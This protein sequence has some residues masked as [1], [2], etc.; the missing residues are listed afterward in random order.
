MYLCLLAFQTVHRHK[1]ESAPPWDTRSPLHATALSL[2][3]SRA[4]KRA[5]MKHTLSNPSN[6]AF[7]PKPKTV[8]IHYTALYRDTKLLT[9]NQII[10]LKSLGFDCRIYN[11][12]NM[13]V[14]VKTAWTMRSNSSQ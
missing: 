13:D 3:L 1:R 8:Q 10:Y 5:S 14:I 9:H 7:P 12:C 4:G 2:M 11:L 6:R